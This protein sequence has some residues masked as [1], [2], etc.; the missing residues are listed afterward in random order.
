M[1]SV[2]HLGLFPFCLP[3]SNLV[4]TQPD[5]GYSDLDSAM[6]L[7]W[8][9][10]KFKWSATLT[11]REGTSSLCT[12]I[13][14]RIESSETELVCFNQYSDNGVLDYYTVENSGYDYFVGYITAASRF[15]V[16]I[17][18]QNRV[19][20]ELGFVGTNPNLRDGWTIFPYDVPDFPAPISLV[21]YTFSDYKLNLW[22]AGGDYITPTFEVMEWWPYDPND[23]GGPI[24][25]S[26]TGARIRND[27]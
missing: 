16:W 19:Y 12:S 5:F 6:A 8:R 22:T 26:S 24:Y 27:V 15:G 4:S 17:D 10:K 7:F 20:S 25:N 21:E 2:H 14:T 23:G 1:A 11:D 9:V 3:L 13:F 18:G